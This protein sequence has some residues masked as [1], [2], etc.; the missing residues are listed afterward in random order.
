MKLI[1]TY[2]ESQIPGNMAYPVWVYFMFRDARRILRGSPNEK[3]LLESGYLYC[4]IHRSRGT[5]DSQRYWRIYHMESESTDY[6]SVA[7][8]PL[9]GPILLDK[10]KWYQLKK[11]FTKQ[12][13]WNKL[14]E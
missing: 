4:I 1:A 12:Y 10:I 6:R 11:H 14:W 3:H 2:K 9:P 13:K 8:I 7:V 5:L